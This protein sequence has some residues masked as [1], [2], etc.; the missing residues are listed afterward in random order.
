M[1]YTAKKRNCK[2]KNN[3][4]LAQTEC[5]SFLFKKN[6]LVW[7]FS[8]KFGGIC[9]VHNWRYRFFKGKH[10]NFRQISMSKDNK[11][12]LYP[13][14]PW[15]FMFYPLTYAT[16]K[17]EMLT[18]TLQKEICIWRHIILV[19]SHIILDDVIFSKFLAKT[20]KSKNT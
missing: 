7:T 8:S 3:I 2:D 5:L 12:H 19:W 17:D 11:I 1:N 9:H 15:R 6:N 13:L 4:K 10:S 18:K 16:P 14:I 20:R